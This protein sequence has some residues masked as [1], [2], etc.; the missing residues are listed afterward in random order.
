GR[1]IKIF[2][3]NGSHLRVLWPSSTIL[4]VPVAPVLPLEVP[5]WLGP[6]R[7]PRGAADPVRGLHAARRRVFRERATR[8][9]RG[10]RR[11][12]RR[13][14][15]GSRRGGGRARGPRTPSSPAIRRR[16]AGSPSPTSPCPVPA[17]R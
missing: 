17:P 14:C 4:A 5:I 10:G 1:Y 12:R 2:Y 13:P 3:F 11:C 16:G 8:S 15:V 9:C 7:R 6:P